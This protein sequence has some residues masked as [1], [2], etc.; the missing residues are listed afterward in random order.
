MELCVKCVNKD[1]D[2]DDEV[3]SKPPDVDT[4]TRKAF[5]TKRRRMV[6]WRESDDKR[7]DNLSVVASH[8]RDFKFQCRGECERNRSQ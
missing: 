4:K 2:Y 5:H 7:K 3:T 8:P 1:Y 6:Q